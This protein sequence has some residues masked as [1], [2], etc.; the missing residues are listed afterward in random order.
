MGLGGYI[1]CE[2][3]S[4]SMEDPRFK[5]A[6][7]NLETR[8][9]NLCTEKWHPSK[10]PM[11]ACGYLT[12][13][14]GQFGRTSIL[15]E[16]FNGADDVQMAHW[17]QTLDTAGHQTLISG[18]GSGNTLA[19][20]FMVALIGFAFPN[21]QQ[22]ITEIKM[23]IGDRKYGRINLEEMHGYNKPALILEEGVIINEKESFE[24]Y[25]YVEG[26]IPNQAPFCNR[27]YQRVVLLG[28][29]YYDVISDVLGNCGAAIT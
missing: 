12:P 17:R 14:A 28:A 9:I 16:L 11:E 20:D 10:T 26:P 8:A 3:H 2:Q 24:L 23:Q 19:E 5:Q 7:K 21:K 15:P 29:T 25:G 22:H 13:G 18:A 4:I 6:F 27:L 1:F